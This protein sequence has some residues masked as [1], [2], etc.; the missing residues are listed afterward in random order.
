M[1][2]NSYI[3]DIYVDPDSDFVLLLLAVHFNANH[4]TCVQFR[5]QDFLPE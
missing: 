3:V 2:A 1:F 4:F 5:M